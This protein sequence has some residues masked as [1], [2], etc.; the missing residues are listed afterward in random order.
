MNKSDVIRKVAKANGVSIKVS[1][2][3][4]DGFLDVLV[5]ELNAK[6]KVSLRAFGVFSTAE[7]KAYKSKNPST[8]KPISVPV[9][10]RILFKP[11]VTLKRSVN[12]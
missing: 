12:L 8:G 4:I 3:V 9:T 7:R 5:D 2:D 11:S 6:S 10:T 1:Q